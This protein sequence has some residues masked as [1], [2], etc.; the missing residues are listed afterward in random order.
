M[1]GVLDKK[2]TLIEIQLNDQQNFLE[3]SLNYWSRLYAS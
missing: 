3:R 1:P 2:Q